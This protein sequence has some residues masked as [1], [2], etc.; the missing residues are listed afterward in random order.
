M[1]VA[2]LPDFNQF[3]ENRRN[4]IFVFKKDDFWLSSDTYFF[5]FLS[6]VEQNALCRQ[7]PRFIL[8]MTVAIASVAS[9]Q[10]RKGLRS[11]T[12]HK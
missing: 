8:K 6:L 12:T 10:S 4:K 5:R 1:T 11:S 9:L 2:S 3:N 7:M